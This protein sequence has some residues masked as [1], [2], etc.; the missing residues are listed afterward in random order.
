MTKHII[1]LGQFDD[2]KPVEFDLGIFNRTKGSFIANSGGGKTFGMGTLI[3]RSIEHIQWVIVDPEGEYSPLRKMFPKI[4][5]VGEEG[6]LPVNAKTAKLLA[7]KIMENRLSTIIDL[8]GLL[9]IRADWTADFITALINMPKDLW[10]PVIVAIDEAHRLAP[11]VPEGNKVERE[12]VGRSRQAITSLADSGRKQLR[13]VIVASQ[14]VSKLAAN[15]RAELRNRFIGL[16]VQDIDRQRAADDLGFSKQQALALRDM[17]PGQFYAFGP[18]FGFKGIQLIQMDLP[19]TPFPKPGAQRLVKVPPPD[20]ALKM[21]VQ[22][23][24]DLPMQVQAEGDRLTAVESQNVELKRR[25]QT[26]QI[27]LEQRPPVTTPPEI[28]R[29]EVPVF[30][31]EQ[32]SL[33]K[34]LVANT[35]TVVDRSSEITEQIGRLLELPKQLQPLI[36]FLAKVTIPAPTHFNVTRGSDNTIYAYGKP[37]QIA[38]RIDVGVGVGSGKLPVGEMKILTAC[39][40]H[41]NGCTRQQLTV[42]TGY[43]RSSRDAYIARLLQKALIGVD[44]GRLYASVHGV[45]ELGNNFKPLP[46]G[47]DLQ[48]YWSSH[49]PEGERVIYEQVLLAYPKAL[50]RDEVDGRYKRSSRNAYIARLLAKEL[51]TTPTAGQVRA[52]DDLFD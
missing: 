14:R 2:G 48:A 52:S 15:A 39:A 50:A 10:S 37:K 3:E 40:Q 44:D 4:L 26:L 8:Y 7:R 28:Q 35:A 43:K 6:E 51:I 47:D 23:M 20:D 18:A 45:A 38:E 21:V 49:L 11:E 16:H 24:G 5:L 31:K 46:V 41:R 17:E 42:L 29:V 1:T 32:E 13:G 12:A 9:S 22:Q 36:Q 27:Q 33:L 34:R 19:Q 30:T 25:L